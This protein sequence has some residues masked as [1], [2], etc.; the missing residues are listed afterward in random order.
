MAGQ[1]NRAEKTSQVKTCEGATAPG[2]T[3]TTRIMNINEHW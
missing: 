1:D 3:E 2:S